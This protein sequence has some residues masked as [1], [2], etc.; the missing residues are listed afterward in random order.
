MN[1]NFIEILKKKK[2]YYGDVDAANEFALQ[3]FLQINVIDTLNFIKNG[4][5][6]KML[7][8]CPDGCMYSGK[9]YNK[10]SDYDPLNPESEHRHIIKLKLKEKCIQK[11]FNELLQI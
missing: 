10:L 2:L 7:S 9:T 4:N 5:Y 6:E 3:E 1:N 8:Y 11:L